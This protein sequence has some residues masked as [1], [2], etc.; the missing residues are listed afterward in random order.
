MADITLTCAQCGNSITI[1]EFV[2]A[3]TL[4]CMRCKAQVP[5]PA[6]SEGAAPAQPKLRIA[7]PPPPPPPPPPVAPPSGKAARRSNVQQYLP[8]AKSRPQR[9]RRASNFEVKVLPWL[10]FVVFTSVSAW[11]RYVPGVLS[12]DLHFALVQS[13]V[14]ILLFLHISMVCYAFTDDAFFGVLCLIIPGYSIYYLFA[15]SD[16]MIIRAVAAAL[17]IAFG[18]D[19]LLAARAVWIDVYVSV[20]HWIATTD[21]IK[22]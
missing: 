10:L 4:T 7:A 14:W 17:L 9:A 13:G 2:A 16:R 3:E 12:P 1:S 5:V 20:S 21:S 11:L 15:Q 19:A 6:R 8:K 18:W 22:K